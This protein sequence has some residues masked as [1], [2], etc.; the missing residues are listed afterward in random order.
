M[1]EGNVWPQAEINRRKAARRQRHVL[2]A[3]DLEDRAALDPVDRVAVDLEGRA[4]NP[5]ADRV[6]NPAAN[7]A[8]GQGLVMIEPPTAVGVP[9]AREGF[10]PPASE[11]G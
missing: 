10:R 2:A 7:P 3:L 6:A 1:K 5:A 8:V 4:V 11:Q 9:V